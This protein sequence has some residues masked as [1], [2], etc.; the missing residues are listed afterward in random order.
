MDSFPPFVAAA[1]S[2]GQPVHDFRHGE[3]GSSSRRM[4]VRDLKFPGSVTPTVGFR[5]TSARSLPLIALVLSMR[6]SI[7]S[8]ATRAVR[9]ARGPAHRGALSSSFRPAGRR[10]IGHGGFALL[11][12]IGSDVLAKS[13]LGRGMRFGR[14]IS[15]TTLLPEHPVPGRSRNT[16]SYG[17]LL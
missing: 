5:D 4:I 17:G 1:I 10:S 3:R 12:Y 2:V 7:R 9:Y 13:A 8:N 14:P 16:F 15:A 6:R 11:N